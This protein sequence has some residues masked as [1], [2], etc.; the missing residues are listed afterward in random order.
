MPQGYSTNVGEKG[1]Q[2]SGGQR[3]RVAIARALVRDPP[4]LILDEVALLPPPR[5]IASRAHGSLA[6]CL[7]AALALAAP[8]ARECLCLLANACWRNRHCL[9]LLEALDCFTKSITV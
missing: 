1:N 5:S 8:P 3:Q 6:H 9:L 2:L 4:I 7:A